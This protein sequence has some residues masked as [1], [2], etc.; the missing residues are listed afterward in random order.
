MPSPVPHFA[1]RL[2]RHATKPSGSRPW[3]ED[4]PHGRHCCPPAP[5]GVCGAGSHGAD[6]AA[7]RRRPCA[8]TCGAGSHGADRAGAASAVCRYPNVP[9]CWSVTSGRLPCLS[10]SGW[11]APSLSRRSL[12]EVGQ[13]RSGFRVADDR[14][15]CR[16]PPAGLPRQRRRR[17]FTWGI[18]E[19][20]SARR[21]QSRTSARGGDRERWLIWQP[22]PL[23]SGVGEGR[24]ARCLRR[25]PIG[26]LVDRRVS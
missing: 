16:D 5:I 10:R 3:S 24:R 26:G 18:H 17:C 23:G 12:A 11:S 1:I 8:G 14:R 9:K 21:A 15:W 13:C 19:F 4:D 6:R 22:D 25:R 20:T 2:V 7:A